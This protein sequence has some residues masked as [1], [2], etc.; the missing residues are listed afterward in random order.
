VVEFDH[1]INFAQFHDAA[2]LRVEAAQAEQGISPRSAIRSA[3]ESLL[4]EAGPAWNLQK[5]FAP[6]NQFGSKFT[7]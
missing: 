5:Y 4:R 1:S 6:V 2:L 7:H 3:T